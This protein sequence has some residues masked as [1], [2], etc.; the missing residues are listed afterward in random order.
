MPKDI[1]IY[2]L[3][4]DI[5][6]FFSLYPFIMNNK[7][8][9]SIH[10]TN[11]INYVL[12]KSTEKTIIIFRFLKRKEIRHDIVTLQ[13]IRDK[14]KN[15]IY[16]DDTAGTDELNLAVFPYVDRYLKKQINKDRSFYLEPSYGD[17]IY[18]KYYHEKYGI[19]DNLEI[20]R[21]GLKQEWIDKIEVSWNLGIGCYPKLPYRN[22]IA[23]RMHQFVGVKGLKPLYSQPEK[24]SNRNISINKISARYGMKFSKETVTYHR[25]I[26][27]NT[28]EKNDLFLT[29]RVPLKVYNSE[30]QKVKG[31]FS[32]FGW[33]EV[34]FRDF[35]AIIN[36]SALIKPS[37]E[38]VDTWPNIYKS[39]E[40][41][42]PV[43][44]DGSDLEDRAQTLMNNPYQ[45]ELLTS[46]ALE[47]FRDAYK[48]LDKRVEE[49]IFSTL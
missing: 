12:H 25:G 9:N 2:Y 11:D 18:S 16:F 40:T 26:Y 36:G 15:V 5:T 42:C 8:K 7:F 49:L 44:W 14:F 17:R 31:T 37:M 38:H 10:F 4:D 6:L 3:E 35:E 13:K 33:G 22:G 20:A 28:V 19:S 29:G 21:E 24:Y 27:Q 45:L 39:N 41:Y 48:Q 47:I 1:C 43:D 46:N 23:R 32:P 30:L 34:C